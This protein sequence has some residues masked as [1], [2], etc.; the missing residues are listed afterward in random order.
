MQQRFS[1]SPQKRQVSKESLTDDPRRLVEVVLTHWRE[2]FSTTRVQENETDF[3]YLLTSEGWKHLQ[4]VISNA[5]SEGGAMWLEQIKSEYPNLYWAVDL[6]ANKSPQE[7]VQAAVDE[8]GTLAY[9]FQSQIVEIHKRLK[10][11][12]DRPRF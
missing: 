3:Q 4:E 8:Y 10:E 2:V 6:A 9:L 11:E 5:R 1:Q 12:I 7:A